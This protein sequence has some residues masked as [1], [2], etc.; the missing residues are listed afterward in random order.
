MEQLI[1]KHQKLDV[2]FSSI[3]IPM[4]CTYSSELFNNHTDNTKNFIKDFIE[5]CNNLHEDF[6]KKISTNV[7]IILMLLPVPNK[8]D[9]NSELDTRLK[10]MQ[11]I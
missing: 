10:R 6:R 9:L 7:K 11:G 5:E 3:V 1:H 4:V 8:N 2:V